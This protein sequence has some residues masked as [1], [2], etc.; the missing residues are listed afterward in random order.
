LKA[1]HHNLVSSAL[2]QALSTWVSWGQAASPYLDE[3]RR[4]RLVQHEI[5]PK[6]LEAVLGPLL[7]ARQMLPSITTSSN[8]S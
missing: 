8:A 3:H 1:V 2:I 6:E 7:R 4:R 5:Q